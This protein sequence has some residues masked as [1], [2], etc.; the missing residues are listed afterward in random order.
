MWLI[1]A[2]DDNRRFVAQDD[3][4]ARMLITE[5]FDRLDRMINSRRRNAAMIRS[6]FEIADRVVTRAADDRG[7]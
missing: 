5:R 7:I 1:E 4:R 3:Q 2:V 6:V